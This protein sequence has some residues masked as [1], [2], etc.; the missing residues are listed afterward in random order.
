MIIG[1]SIKLPLLLITFKVLLPTLIQFCIG[2]HQISSLRSLKYLN[3]NF[4]CDHGFGKVSY[5]QP[6]VNLHKCNASETIT[7][8]LCKRRSSRS[9]PTR[10]AT[11]RVTSG[12]HNRP[13]KRPRHFRLHVIACYRLVRRRGGIQNSGND[14]YPRHYVVHYIVYIVGDSLCAPVIAPTA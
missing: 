8:I 7:I 4:L 3:K 10:L 12:R 11:S 1:S 2:Y 5:K 13:N 6:L 9:V 14:D